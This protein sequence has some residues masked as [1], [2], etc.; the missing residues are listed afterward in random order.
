MAYPNVQAELEPI[1]KRN[2]A[3]ERGRSGIRSREHHFDRDD[4]PEMDRPRHNI[5]QALLERVI[6]ILVCNRPF[7]ETHRST[8]AG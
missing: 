4:A 7:E 2:D 8:V 3:T 5:A 6:T 1:G